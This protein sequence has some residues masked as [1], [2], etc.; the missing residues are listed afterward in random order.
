MK[1]MPFHISK[2]VVR[3]DDYFALRKITVFSNRNNIDQELQQ[4]Q[5]VVSL[6]EIAYLSG[7]FGKPL[8]GF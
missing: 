8:I 4:F 1:Q 3:I 7:P 6:Y 2:F 5:S